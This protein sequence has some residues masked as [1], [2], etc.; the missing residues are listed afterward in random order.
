MLGTY[1]TTN[2]YDCHE[3]YRTIND[4]LISLYISCV[5]SVF[6]YVKYLYDIYRYTTCI[7]SRMNYECRKKI[8]SLKRSLA[9][10]TFQAYRNKK[11]GSALSTG[12]QRKSRRLVTGM[13][14]KTP[15]TEQHFIANCIRT[16][17]L[18]GFGNYY[19]AYSTWL[20]YYLTELLLDW[21]STWLN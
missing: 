19:N 5:K 16:H 21:A 14:M 15:E 18:R 4:Y 17:W 10:S 3:K 8:S 9:C 7:W 13:S 11:L 6:K 12:S 1:Q 2:V 20:N